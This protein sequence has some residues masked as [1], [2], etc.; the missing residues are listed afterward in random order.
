M[1]VTS[2]ALLVCA[3]VLAAAVTVWAMSSFGVLTVIPVLLAVALLAR[4]A[5][6]HV[7][8]DDTRT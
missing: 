4:W 3:V 5:M 8:H 2:F 7:P 1:P 6:A